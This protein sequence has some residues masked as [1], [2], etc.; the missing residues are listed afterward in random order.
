VA[1]SVK[2]PMA[3]YEAN[4]SAIG[5]EVVV[6]HASNDFTYFA[7]GIYVGGAGDVA[8]VFPDST[9]QI[10]SAVPAGTQLMVCCRRVNAVGTTATLMTTLI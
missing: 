3:G 9:V 8:V 10:Y 7:R 6:P 1:I 5:G 4:L 2:Q